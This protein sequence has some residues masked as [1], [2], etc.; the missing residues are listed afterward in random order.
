MFARLVSCGGAAFWNVWRGR[1]MGGFGACI[2]TLWTGYIASCFN[3]IDAMM[4]HTILV[5]VS[6]DACKLG[7]GIGRLA[8]ESRDY[9][10]TT[11]HVVKKAKV[12]VNKTLLR[13]RETGIKQA[14]NRNSPGTLSV[15]RIKSS[16]IEAHPY[17]V[18]PCAAKRGVP[19]LN[20]L[21]QCLSKIDMNLRNRVPSIFYLDKR[22]CRRPTH[23]LDSRRTFRRGQRHRSR[24]ERWWKFQCIHSGS[25]LFAGCC[26]S[27]ACADALQ[28]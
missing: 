14:R 16:A 1:V 15:L 6:I 17:V 5:R 12:I 11:Q 8:G 22:L 20:T 9:S 10:G 27:Q 7:M 13:K 28:E 24:W 25:R 26:A 19:I 21:S 23:W 3:G 2:L 4:S 18:S